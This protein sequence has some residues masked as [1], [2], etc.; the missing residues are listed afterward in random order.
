MASEWGNSGNS[1]WLYFSGLQ[2]RVDGDCNHE[3]KRHLLF[4]RKV[5]TKL[6]SIWK[7]RDI[8]FLANV[9]LVK[10][11]VSPVVLY[12]CE[13]WTVKKA[14]HWK[15]DAFELWCRRRLMRFPCTA[16]VSNQFILRRSVLGVLRKDYV[17]AET[18]ILWTP[19]AE[20]WL[21]WKYPN[22]RKEWGQEEKG[23]TKD[24]MVGW[25]HWHNGHGFGWTLGV[26]DE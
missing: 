26:G 1:G 21:I 6:D 17:E 10:T 11:M 23:T 15:I 18:P 2:N 9:Y 25:H 3:I 24:E 20:N 4:G 22:A 12:G 5:M 13:S 16:R 8:T 14:E 7:S 19:D